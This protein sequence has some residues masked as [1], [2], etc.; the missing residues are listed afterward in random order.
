MEAREVVEQL[1]KSYCGCN[2]EVHEAAEKLEREL[3]AKDLKMLLDI[4]REE[5]CQDMNIAISAA[6]QILRI[7]RKLVSS[8]IASAVLPSITQIILS[9]A[10]SSRKSRSFLESALSSLNSQHSVLSLSRSQPCVQT[11]A[12]ALPASSVY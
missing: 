6:I 10:Y 8:E 4:V 3:E 5:G 9:S 1:R 2:E 12:R 7:A 11:V